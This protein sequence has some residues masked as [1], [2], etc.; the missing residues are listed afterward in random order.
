MSEQASTRL[1]VPHAC[2]CPLRDTLVRS[3]TNYGR[4]IQKFSIVMELLKLFK[5]NNQI[6]KSWSIKGRTEV[7][8]VLVGEFR[9]TSVATEHKGGRKSPVRGEIITHTGEHDKTR[10]FVLVICQPLT[11]GHI[12]I[13][14]KGILYNND[15][16]MYTPLKSAPRGEFIYS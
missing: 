6:L 7:G 13:V 9:K 14:R 3:K 12:L 5:R 8:L 1:F 10:G 16:A 2:T 4:A 11:L 15:E